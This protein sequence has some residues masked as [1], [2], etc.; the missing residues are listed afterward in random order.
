METNKSTDS[1]GARHSQSGR[2]LLVFVLVG[3]DALSDILQR[4]SN[5]SLCFYLYG[6]VADENYTKWD[7]RTN[8]TGQ[9]VKRR[10]TKSG[11][12][13]SYERNQN[14]LGK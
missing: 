4:S 7:L 14:I 3:T 1:R 8:V 5:V 13:F 11:I 9:F 12:K 6:A 2:T 10:M